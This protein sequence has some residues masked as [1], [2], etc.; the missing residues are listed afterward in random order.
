[1]ARHD[2]GD[3]GKAERLAGM[4]AAGI[5]CEMTLAYLSRQFSAGLMAAAALVLGSCNSDDR[6]QLSGST[7]GNTTEVDPTVIPTFTTAEPVDPTTGGP[8]PPS[9][10]TCRKAVACAVQCALMIPS[11]TPPE[12]D[13]QAC[14]FKPECLGELNYVEWLIFFDLVECTVDKCS[15]TQPCIDGDDEGCQACYLLTIGTQKLPE[16]EMC[17][18]E[19]AACD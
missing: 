18:A 4:A 11:P 3:R 6:E 1:M 10:T 15:M 9:P 8:V 16:G 5:V 17:R 19:A 2:G 12:Y 14:F 7:S 13:W